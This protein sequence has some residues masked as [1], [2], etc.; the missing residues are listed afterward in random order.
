MQSLYTRG[1]CCP[2]WVTHCLMM[3]LVCLTVTEAGYFRLISEEDNMVT[4]GT[5]NAVFNISLDDPMTW[6][7]SS[8][9]PGPGELSGLGGLRSIMLLN[10]RIEMEINEMFDSKPHCTSH[11]IPEARQAALCR[12]FVKNV[13]H[14]MQPWTP[15][16]YFPTFTQLQKLR[17]LMKDDIQR[18]KQ[19]AFCRSTCFVCSSDAISVISVI[20]H[21]CILLNK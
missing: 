11:T 8:Y 14:S 15:S 7:P 5:P 10:R 20:L 19:D 12:S 9:K 2:K 21:C 13:I 16:S 3:L 6:A 17:G 18:R 1:M 4:I